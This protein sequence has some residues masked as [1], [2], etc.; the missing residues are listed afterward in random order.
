MISTTW[1]KAPAD[2]LGLGSFDVC[3]ASVAGAGSALRLAAVG[4]PFGTTRLPIGGG[5]VRLRPATRQPVGHDG[6]TANVTQNNGATLGIPSS[7]RP[8][9]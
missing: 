7:R 8:Q 4:A 5:A 3:P 2:L 6:V 9:S 1:T